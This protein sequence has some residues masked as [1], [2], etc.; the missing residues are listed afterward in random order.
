[1]TFYETRFPEDISYGSTGGPEFVTNIIETNNGN[2]YRKINISY[3]RNKYNIMYSVK[4][5]EE[6]LKLIN[7]FYIHKGK[8]IGFRFK[9]WADYKATKQKIGIG[10]NYKTTF[11]L[12]KTYQVGQFSYARTIRKPVINTVKIYYNDSI[13]NNGFS[14]NY[15]NGQIE[16]DVPPNNGIEIYADYEFDVPVR[17]D[18]DYLS[19]SIDNYKQYNCNNIT[20]IEIKT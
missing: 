19:Y 18:L 14:I 3:P 4:S 8:A 1:M 9:D 6:L 12:V 15:S 5:G 13:K 7:F 2:E 17:F 16:F 20:L 11:Q 10:N